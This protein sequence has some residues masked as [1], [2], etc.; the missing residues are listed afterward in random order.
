M[1]KKAGQNSQELKDFLREQYNAIQ[2]LLDDRESI[3]AS[4]N[5]IRAAVK[6]HG[7]TKQAFDRALKYSR[8]DPDKRKEDDV[9]YGICR[10]VLNLP[11]QPDL[12][13]VVAERGKQSAT[14]SED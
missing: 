4:I 7:I 10:D 6:A 9:A 2:P 12:F 14:A 5:E 8:T 11:I 3:N 13:D 1:T